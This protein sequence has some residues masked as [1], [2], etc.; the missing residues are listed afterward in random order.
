M[1]SAE[2]FSGGSSAHIVLPSGDLLF[3]V[4]TAESSCGSVH[5]QPGHAPTGADDLLDL[6]Q[7]V[8][9][10]SQAEQVALPGREPFQRL[11]D[12]H[13]ITPCRVTVLWIFD[14]LAAR[15]VTLRA[16]ITIQ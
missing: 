9:C 2:G 5:M 3:L 7:L 1:P 13:A 11:L 8:A 10:S 12:I 15:E 16:D 4:D 14:H 6:S